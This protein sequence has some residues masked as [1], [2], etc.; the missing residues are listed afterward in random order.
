MIPLEYKTVLNY[1]IA[2]FEERKSRFISTV[3]P[4]T[5]EEEAI[6]FINQLKSKYWDASHNVYAYCIGGGNIIQRFSDDGEPSG[7]A[8]LPVLEVIKRME[9]QDVVVVVTRYFGGIQLGASG[10]VR[11]YAKSA[12]LGIEASGVVTKKLCKE[13]YVMLE[14]PVF[15][16][17]R[18]QVINYG[19]TIKDIKYTQN[20]DMIIM[21]PIDEMD[22]FDEYINEATNGEALVTV[23][24]KEYV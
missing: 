11:A 21:V 7:T 20:V 18:N 16:K 1:A 14:Y 10:L 24:E 17:V 22:R 12:S 13:V 23:G 4:V 19:Y 3:K 8:G 5:T 15:D 2:E 9:L 6:E